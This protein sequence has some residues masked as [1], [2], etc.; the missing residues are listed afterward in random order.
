MFKFQSN[1][2]TCEHNIR[3][4]TSLVNSSNMFLFITELYLLSKYKEIQI[5]QKMGNEEERNLVAC[6]TKCYERYEYSARSV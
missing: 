6:A 2:K 5:E 3:L 4:Q 1:N